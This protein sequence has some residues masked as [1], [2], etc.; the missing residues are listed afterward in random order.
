MK[1][2]ID[3]GMLC[4]EEGSDEILIVSFFAHDSLLPTTKRR[5][6]LSP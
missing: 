3:E 4:G 1:E 6:L 2:M 5:S